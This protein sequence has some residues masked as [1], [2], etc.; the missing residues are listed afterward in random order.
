MQTVSTVSN[1]LHSM[2][3]IS[4]R[5]DLE[6]A[7]FYQLPKDVRVYLTKDEFDAITARLTQNYQDNLATPRRKGNTVSKNLAKVWRNM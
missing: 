3:V 4:A 6:I 2:A 7:L 1:N 5:G